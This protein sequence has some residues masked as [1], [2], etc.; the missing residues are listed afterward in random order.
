V[1]E[2]HW[3]GAAALPAAPRHRRLGGRPATRSAAAR[4]ALALVTL[5]CAPCPKHIMQSAR[6]GT[7]PCDRNAAS[8]TTQ[9]HAVEPDVRRGWSDPHLRLSGRLVALLFLQHLCRHAVR[10]AL[11]R[12]V[13]SSRLL[14]TLPG[15]PCCARAALLDGPP[16][17]PLLPI[18][19]LPFCCA[20][21]PRAH[22]ALSDSTPPQ[23]RR[24]RHLA[25]HH[26]P[27]R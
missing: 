9:L 16:P 25:T 24:S 10:R 6:K 8:L 4:L 7:H 23:E 12:D 1:R 17:A 11:L 3:A 19:C 26:P 18:C 20:P 22:H 15:R 14:C 21:H 5:W 13:L 2:V 27:V